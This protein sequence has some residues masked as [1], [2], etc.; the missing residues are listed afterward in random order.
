LPESAS[1]LIYLERER[2]KPMDIEKFKELK[3]LNRSAQV[4]PQLK[5]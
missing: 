1:K 2:G 4:I 5:A 3:K